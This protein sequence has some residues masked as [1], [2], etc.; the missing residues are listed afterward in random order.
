MSRLPWEHAMHH[1]AG[2]G[3]QP[4]GWE[5]QT[6]W[7]P[8]HMC[9]SPERAVRMSTSWWRMQPP[10]IYSDITRTLQLYE[11]PSL[12]CVKIQPTVSDWSTFNESCTAPIYI[13]WNFTLAAWI[14]RQ[15]PTQLLTDNLEGPG[16]SYIAAITR[17]CTHTDIEMEIYTS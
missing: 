16:I 1:A 17:I 6:N 7:G 3:L 14:P 11:F 15:T 10:R 5:M 4:D 9:A 12:A 13:Q 8:H 2:C